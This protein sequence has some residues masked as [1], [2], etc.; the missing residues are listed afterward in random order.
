[1]QPFEQIGMAKLFLPHRVKFGDI[2]GFKDQSR[3]AL[4]QK[5]PTMGRYVE[6]LSVLPISEVY[7]FDS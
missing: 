5:D 6:L 1:M 3:E 7:P 2:Y 4:K